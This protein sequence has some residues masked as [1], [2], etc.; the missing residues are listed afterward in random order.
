MF[1]IFKGGNSKYKRSESIDS[2]NMTITRSAEHGI[3]HSR[4]VCI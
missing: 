2:Y 1:K 3:T 4:Q